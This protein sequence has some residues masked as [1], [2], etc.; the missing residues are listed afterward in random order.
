MKKYF[1]TG[2]IALL[3]LTI[4]IWTIFFLLNFLTNPFLSFVHTATDQSTWMHNTWIYHPYLMEMVVRVAILI[5]LVLAIL[6]IGFLAN[7]FITKSLFKGL[8][9]FLQRIPFV[10]AIYKTS[11][12]VITTLV[13]S[14]K[15]SFQKVV[16]VPFPSKNRYSI[17]LV[18]GEPSQK[19]QSQ[20][21][22]KLISVF[23]PSCPNPIS[24][25]ILMYEESQI[26]ET[27]LR[28]EDAL[29][30]VISCGMLSIN[31]QQNTKNES[32]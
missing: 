15:Q 8:D 12:Q 6:L 7:T 9:H 2:L 10:K 16:L 13:Y 20:T 24:G 14:K 1:F 30:Y 18:A 19:C 23:M 28:V 32:S 25:F 31:P 21:P 11:H 17:G 22:E 26:I 5:G 29:K 27:S 3:P 4:T